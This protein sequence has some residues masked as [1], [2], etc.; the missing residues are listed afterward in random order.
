[1]HIEET[2]AIALGLLSAVLLGIGWVVAKAVAVAPNSVV[3]VVVPVAA[4]ITLLT[5]FVFVVV[6]RVN[7]KG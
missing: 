4:M 7:V 5:F 3:R 6:A 1:V 2:Y